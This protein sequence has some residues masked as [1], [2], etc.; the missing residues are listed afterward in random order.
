MKKLYRSAL[1]ARQDIIFANA[2]E[3]TSDIFALCHLGM[4]LTNILRRGRWTRVQLCRDRGDPR[5]LHISQPRILRAFISVIPGAPR[6]TTF[7]TSSS[8]LTL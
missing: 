7:P 2:K 5:L 4:Y 3:K 1:A 8:T 6:K